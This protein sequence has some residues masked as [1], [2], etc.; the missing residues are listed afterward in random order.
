ML[1]KLA[2]INREQNRPSAKKV[3]IR[4]MTMKLKQFKED[5]NPKAAISKELQSVMP[6]DFHTDDSM[7]GIDFKDVKSSSGASS[8]SEEDE[9]DMNSPYRE[10]EKQNKKDKLQEN[11]VTPLMYYQ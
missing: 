5:Q 10:I 8:F 11:L 9:D 1:P 3:F 6:Q 7:K 2:K 4:T